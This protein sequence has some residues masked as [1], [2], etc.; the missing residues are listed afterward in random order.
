MRTH[1]LSGALPRRTH[2]RTTVPGD[3]R[4]RPADLVEREFTPPAP[5]QLWVT[6]ITYVA[7][8]GG[9]FCYAAFVTDAFS[10]ATV[11]W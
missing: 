11:A 1:H 10:R 6:D 5:N 8:P 2:P 7:L 3:E 9:R 4:R